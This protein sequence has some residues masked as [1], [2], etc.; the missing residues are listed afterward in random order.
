MV[1]SLMD[2]ILSTDINTLTWR[3]FSGGS[4]AEGD[5]LF[6]CVY[7]AVSGTENVLDFLW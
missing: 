7:I 1:L 3:K 5:I 6:Y 2:T 4:F